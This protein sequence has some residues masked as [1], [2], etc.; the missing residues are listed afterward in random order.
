MGIM[1]PV[2]CSSR[3]VRASLGLLQSPDGPLEVRSGR[4]Q[5]MV[6]SSLAQYNGKVMCFP[7]AGY[8]PRGPT[9]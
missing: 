2:I 3:C 9:H 6:L 5:H 1:H 7:W 8:H 4:Q